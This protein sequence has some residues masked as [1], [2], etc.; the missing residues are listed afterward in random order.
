MSVLNISFNGSVANIV[1]T[2]RVI[3]ALRFQ[4]VACYFLLLNIFA[5]KYPHFISNTKPIMVLLVNADQ[6]LGNTV[7]PASG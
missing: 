1:H 6:Y 3:I 5:V 7:L 2:G 4:I